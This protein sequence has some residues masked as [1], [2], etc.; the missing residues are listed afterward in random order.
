MKK[1]IKLTLIVALGFMCSSLACE[2]DHTAPVISIIGTNPVIIHIGDGY[3]DEGATAWDDEDGDVTKYLSASSNVDI[4]TAGSYFILYSV[5]DAPG[6]VSEK[7][8]TVII[9][10]SVEYLKGIYNV[11]NTF[12]GGTPVN[13]TDSITPSPIS[14]DRV[15]VSRFANYVNAEVFFDLNPSVHTLQ[16]S[17]QSI[18]CGTPSTLRTF[19]GSG[20]YTVNPVIFT[21]NYTETTGGNT[22]SGLITYTQQ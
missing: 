17:S 14:N 15:F 22:V 1:V 4:N 16:L 5:V 10:N 8:R 13:F 12:N 9:E 20:S 3:T 21:I 6:N 18:S 7:K 2:D 19:A 11:S